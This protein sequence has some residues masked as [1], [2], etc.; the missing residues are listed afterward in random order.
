MGKTNR[1]ALQNENLQRAPG[2]FG[3]AY[4]FGVSQ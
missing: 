4:S 3:R 2:Y 1:G